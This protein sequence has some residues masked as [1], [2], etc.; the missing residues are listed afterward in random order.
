MYGILA[1]CIAVMA[2]FLGLFA[3]TVE[4]EADGFENRVITGP[5]TAGPDQMAQNASRRH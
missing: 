4:P 5:Q 2:V 3:M 1:A